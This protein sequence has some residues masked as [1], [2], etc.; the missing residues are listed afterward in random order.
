MTKKGII[1][2]ILL[3][4]PIINSDAFA[5]MSGDAGVPGVV[6]DFI[7]FFTGRIGRAIC[8]ISLMGISFLLFNGSISWQKAIMLMAGFGLMFNA[9]NFAIM[10][11]PGTITNVQ[12]MIGARS[13]S[14]SMVY[15]PEEIIA[16]S[17]P[18]L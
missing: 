3:C 15:T 8:I 10:L 6:C 18:A 1:F 9:K 12:G 16:A 2:A 5:I 11:L 7:L 14:S 4:T 13:F 17:C